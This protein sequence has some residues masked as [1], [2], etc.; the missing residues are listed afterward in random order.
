VRHRQ[1]GD[2]ELR[3]GEQLRDNAAAS[4]VDLDEAA[5]QEIEAVFA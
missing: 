3:A 1:L 5:L 2:S 4:H